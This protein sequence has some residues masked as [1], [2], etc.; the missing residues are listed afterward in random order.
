M[1]KRMLPAAAALWLLGGCAVVRHAEIPV[2]ERREPDPRAMRVFSEG[3]VHEMNGDFTEAALRYHEALLYDPYSAGIMLALGKAYLQLDREESAMVLLR[4]CQT[5]DPNEVEASELLARIYAGQG[6]WTL[7]EKTLTGILAKDSTRAETYQQLAAFYLRQDNPEKAVEMYAKILALKDDAEPPVFLTLGE[8]YMKAGQFDEAAEVY[9]RL[10]AAHP[11]EGS[12][13]FGLGL[14]S[15]AAG[16]TMQAQAYYEKALSLSPDFSEARDRL[17]D[18]HMS[19]QE[20]ERAEAL[21]R[22]AVASDSTDLP[23]WLKLADVYGIQEDSLAAVSTHQRI[24]KLFPDEWRAHLNRGRFLLEHREYALSLSEFRRVIELAPKLSLGWFFSGVAHI[25]LDSLEKSI[26]FLEKALEITPD[27]PM[28]NFY[29]GSVFSQLE[30]HARAVAP[31]QKA[32]QG[33]PKWI[34]AISALASSYESLKQYPLSDSLYHLALSIDPENAMILNNW[35]YSLTLR[36]QRLDEALAMAEKA[37]SLDPENGAYLDTMGWIYYHLGDYEKALGFIQKAYD[38]R[39]DS[40]EVI[41]HLGD[42]YQKIGQTDLAR[43]M[44]G[45]ALELD[46]DN[47]TIRLKLDRTIP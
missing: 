30:N 13:W 12:G 11:E 9:G 40:P 24:E 46:K 1:L 17:A 8:L 4:R 34:S 6:W 38:K 42:V 45:K 28:A 5:A 2:P 19:R 22:E 27:D 32:I 16:D 36:G 47:E 43:E 7:V 14:A 41:D 35:G 25:Q 15:E 37:I 20:W 26:G 23:S 21:Y 33:R 18:I 44:W 10:T 39:K 31:L 3:V 29:L